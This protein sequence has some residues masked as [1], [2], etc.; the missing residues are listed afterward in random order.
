MSD[1]A[2]KSMLRKAINRADI[3]KTYPISMR[4]IERESM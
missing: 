4:E 3:V 1:L 2:P